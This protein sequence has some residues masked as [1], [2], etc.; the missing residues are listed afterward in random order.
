VKVK[1]SITVLGRPVMGLLYLHTS[2]ENFYR[3]TVKSLAPPGRKQAT[4]TE[5]FDI[6]ICYLLS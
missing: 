3:G 5:E 6:H 2:H 1:N 4:T